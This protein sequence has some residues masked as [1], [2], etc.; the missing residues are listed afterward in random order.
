MKTLK[1]L[2]VANNQPWKSWDKKVTD[3]KTWFA[4]K[5]NL[6]VEIVETAYN[7]IPFTDYNVPA[8][9]VKASDKRGIEFKWFDDHVS[10]LA[11]GYDLVLF[12]VPTLQWDSKAFRGYRTDRDLGPVEMQIAANE[13]ERVIRDGKDAGGVWWNMARHELMHALF[14]L[15]G[16]PDTT[17]FWWD[18][19]KLETALDE[20]AFPTES[21]VDKQG[22]IQKLINLI[23]Q[24]LGFVQKE[25]DRI[26][27]ENSTSIEVPEPTPQKAIDS[28]CLAIQEF[29]GYFAPG[30]NSKYPNGTISWRNNNPGNLR[31]AGQ[32]GMTGSKGGF[33]VFKN[34][35]VG[36]QALYHQVEIACN[37]KSK[38]YHPNMTIL[39]FFSKFAP[40]SDGNYPKI[41]ATF[42]ANKLG[43]S[44]DFVIR[45]LI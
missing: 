36:Y 28:F 39:E 5:V 30:V 23:A 9:Q 11:Q 6:N 44:V 31:P 18:Q 45:N 1:L 17:H 42:V 26:T 10:K 3:L 34:Y 15:T 40:S 25:V 20:I 8:D 24:A 14:M 38:V 13:D 32:I 37:G 22:I 29:E 41:Y 33:A 7:N 27:K 12:S 43:V 35:E 4:P 2:I 21:P 16:Q 19:W